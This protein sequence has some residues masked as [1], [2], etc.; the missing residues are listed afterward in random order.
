MKKLFAVLT[1]LV[2]VVI[3]IGFYRGW[4][5]LSSSEAEKGNTKVN[6]NLTVDREKMREDAQ[7][8]KKRTTEFADNVIG[9]RRTPTGPEDNVAE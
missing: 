6:V 7:A 9:E 1:V 2:L 4:F 5:A 3:G 8:A